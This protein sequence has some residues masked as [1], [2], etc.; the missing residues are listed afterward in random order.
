MVELRLL[1]TVRLATSDHR[2]VQVV[3]AQPRRLALLAYLA[4]ATPHGPQRRDTLLAMFWPEV[5]ERRARAAL[6]Q[7]L[8][9][10]RGALGP[11]VVEGNE[12]IALDARAIRCDVVD[13]EQAVDG[14]RW[15]EALELYKGDLLDGFFISDAPVFEQWQGETCRRVRVGAL[16]N[17]WA[18]MELGA[19]L[20]ESGAAA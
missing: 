18:A 13:F 5:D 6:R 7:S 17:A 12:A 3:V 10:L 15:Q 1:G 14:G 11:D 20:V 19:E 16:L 8:Y 4:V 2:D 9:V